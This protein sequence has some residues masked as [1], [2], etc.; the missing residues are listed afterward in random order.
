MVW[1]VYDRLRV[2]VALFTSA[3]AG[4]VAEVKEELSKD[5]KW[6]TFS[7]VSRLWPPPPTF[8]PSTLTSF[9]EP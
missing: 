6:N 5:V 8:R 4:N 1:H 2:G 9:L 3:G 7:S